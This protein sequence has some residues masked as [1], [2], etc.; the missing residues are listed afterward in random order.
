MDSKTSCEI[1]STNSKI[2][3]FLKATDESEASAEQVEEKLRATD[4]V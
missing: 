3:L 4:R 2:E 1:L